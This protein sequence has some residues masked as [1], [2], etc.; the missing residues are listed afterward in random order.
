MLEVNQIR[1]L[2]KVTKKKPAG[3]VVNTHVMAFYPQKVTGTYWQVPVQ[4]Y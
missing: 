3:R 4:G 1:Q 2:K